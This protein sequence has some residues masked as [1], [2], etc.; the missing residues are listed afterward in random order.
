[1][2]F[3]GRRREEEAFQL[4]CRMDLEG[5]K[6]DRVTFVAIVNACSDSLS[7][8]REI[9]SRI[10]GSGFSSFLEIKNA[11]RE[12]RSGLLETTA[13]GIFRSGQHRDVISWSS[14][15]ESCAHHGRGEESLALFRRMQQEGVDSNAITFLSILSARRQSGFLDGGGAG[16]RGSDGGVLGKKAAALAPWIFLEEL[17]G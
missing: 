13:L 11:S 6:P 9:H 17:G 7:S 3:P 5:V 15:I 12:D 14:M 4:L 8:V 16:L 2:P 10:V 1:M